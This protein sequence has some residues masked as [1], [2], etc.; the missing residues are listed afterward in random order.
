MGQRL[1]SPIRSWR[2][3]R[4]VIVS[5]QDNLPSPLFFFPPLFSSVLFF[6][7]PLFLGRT[8]LLP[9]VPKFWTHAV[10][11]HCGKENLDWGTCPECCRS[12]LEHLCRYACQWCRSVTLT[13]VGGLLEL[14][15]N[16]SRCPS[17]MLLRCVSA[18]CGGRVGCATLARTH[19][20]G[21]GGQ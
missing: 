2:C 10:P 4:A 21:A 13:F 15:P 17:C 8:L 16:M 11:S 3:E 14:S 6:F 9:R 5:L 7:P 18:K 20:R 19:S 12:P 1:T